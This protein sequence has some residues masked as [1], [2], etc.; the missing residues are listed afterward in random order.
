MT[1]LYEGRQHKRMSRESLDCAIMLQELER[2]GVRNIITFDAHDP[3]VQNAIPLSGFESIQPTYQM[4]R[5]ILRT[6]PDIQVDRDHLMIISPDEGAMDRCTYYSSVLGVDLGMFYKRRDYSR[7]VNGK[8]PIVAHVFLGDN[9]EGKDVIVVDDMI[10]TGDS[11]LDIV[12]QL[13]ERKA[14]RIFAVSTF[15]L[16]SEGLDRMDKAYEEGLF[17]RIFTTNLIYRTPELL[18]RPWYTEVDMSKF[19]AHIINVLNHDMSISGL[20]S[21]AQRI[22]QLLEDRARGVDL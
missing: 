19:I 14:R 22:A 17:D 2:L 21:P 1:M 11:T 4:I 7:I 16:F 5:T 9:I 20:L 6:Y 8:N 18:S 3:R 12:R 13:K 10:G 15:G